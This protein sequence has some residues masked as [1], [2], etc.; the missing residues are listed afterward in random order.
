MLEKK[1]MRRA[2]VVQ[3]RSMRR[4]SVGIAVASVAWVAFQLLS[5]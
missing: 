3:K 1:V 5:A 4:W 2:A